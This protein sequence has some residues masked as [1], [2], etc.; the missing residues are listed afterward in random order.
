MGEAEEKE[1][2]EIRGE[3]AGI[4]LKVIKEGE[5]EIRNYQRYILELDKERVYIKTDQTYPS[6]S[7]LKFI[8]DDPKLERKIELTGEA[9]RINRPSAKAG[10]L[11]AGMGIVFDQ[12]NLGDR[13]RLLRF[14]KEKETE[15][16]TSEYLRFLG[17]MK[18]ASKPMPT[19]EKDKIK[20]DLLQ[21][22][23][24]EE[25]QAMTTTKKKREDLE[26]LSHIP[27]FQELDGL[28]LGEIAELLIKEKYEPGRTIF[29][30][31]EAGDKLYIILKGE[32]EIFKPIS[33]GREEILATLKSGDYFGEMSLVDQAPRSASARVG[34]E[35]SALTMSKK[36][37]DL[38]LRASDTMAAK[39]YKFF[40]QTI[41][42]RLRDAD[43]KIKRIVQVLSGPGSG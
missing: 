18:R 5:T 42:K 2:K 7:K 37:F 34:G 9:V 10:S 33:E 1:N 31:G 20:R 12:I 3:E 11:D 36:D 32:V 16:R 19:E 26:I 35:L 6:G 30:E 28:E 21:A 40:V 27:L 29:K 14:F 4:P 17:W 23:Y 15:D 22:L 13:D 38:L 39:I 43:E 25:R 8:F 41:S 24:G